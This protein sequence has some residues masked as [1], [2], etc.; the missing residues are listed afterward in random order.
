M[1]A[2]LTD[3]AN[4][5]EEFARTAS[6]ELKGPITAISG[7][8]ELLLD[9]GDEMTR[10][11][12]LRFLQNIATD[13]RRMERLVTRMLHLA[14]IQGEPEELEELDLGE[15]LAALLEGYQQTIGL[16]VEPGLPAL[17]IVREHLEVAVRN[18][19]DNAVS[20]GGG[21]SIRVRARRRGP[22][23]EIGV[24]DA[25]PGI[26]PANRERIFQRFF[27]TAREAGGTGLGLSIVRAVADARGGS[28]ELDTSPDG[29]EFRL[30]L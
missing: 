23:I 6:H 1:T 30:V 19:L 7:A 21:K 14:Q 17:S 22:R 4:T 10:E 18:L 25:G 29:T 20:H 15:T 16:E 26:S 27:T 13:T 8:T 2:Q 24:F 12:R 11:Q 3:R 9:E 28:L 5:I